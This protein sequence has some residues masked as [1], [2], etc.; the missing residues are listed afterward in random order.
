[1]MAHLF[2]DGVF[3]RNLSVNRVVTFFVDKTRNV[4]SL[5]EIERPQPSVLLHEPDANLPVVDGNN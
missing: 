2:L 1:M 3:I 4:Q 5:S